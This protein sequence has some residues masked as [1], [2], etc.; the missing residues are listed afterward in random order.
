MSR[1]FTIV[2]VSLVATVAFLVG[3]I[4][5]GGLDR[6]RVAA[7]QT[8]EGPRG[9]TVSRVPAPVPASLVSFADVVERLTPAVVSIDATARAGDA[10]MRGLL[11]ELGID[12]EP[13][14]GS[15]SGFIIDAD[16]SI[17]T[18]HHVVAGAER[19]VVRLSDGRSARARVVGSDPDTDIALIKVDDLSG[20][21]VAPLGDSTSLRRGEWVCAIGS[22]LG[23]EQTVTVG[24]VSFVGRTLEDLN[25]DSFIQ[26]DAAI[27]FGNSGGPLINARGEVIGINTA[28][29]SRSSNIGFAVP[30]NAATAILPALRADGRV[31][32]GYMGATMRDVDRDVQQ[33]LSLPI[34]EGALIEDVASDSPAARAGL[35]PYDVVVSIDRV[36]VAGEGDLMRRIAAR[37]PGTTAALGVVRDGA[38]QTLSVK[39]AERPAPAESGTGAGNAPIGARPD[40]DPLLGLTVRELDES[41]AVRMGLSRQARGVFITRVDPLSNAFDADIRRGTVLLEINRQPVG[42]VADYRRLASSARPGDVLALYLHSAIRSHRELKTVRVEEP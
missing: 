9:E 5:A 20:L 32:R 14:R 2:G 29:S 35:R 31:L 11:G 22:P 42:S 18:N 10:R 16:G 24:V 38:H 1:R 12:R 17:L 26:T 40:Q 36:A 13:R 21:P 19:I 34:G 4:V 25:L 37:V 27:S 30:I 8:D 23:Y 39:L 3:A 6:S 28:V 33:S 15:G 41:T 7:G